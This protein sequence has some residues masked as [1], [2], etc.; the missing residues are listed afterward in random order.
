MGGICSETQKGETIADAGFDVVT[1]ATNLSITW[2]KGG[3][4]TTDHASLP[5]SAPDSFS[6]NSASGMGR[7]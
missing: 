3:R 5:D 4:Y 6:S 2:H 7:E 1:C